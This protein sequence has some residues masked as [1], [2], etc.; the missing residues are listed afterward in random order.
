MGFRKNLI[1]L[2]LA[3]SLVLAGTACSKKL[4]SDETGTS[5]SGAESVDDGPYSFSVLDKKINDYN[6]E[7][8]K[9]MKDHLGETTSKET[10]GATPGGVP[11]ICKYTLTNDNKFE[12]LQMEKTLSNGMQVDEYFNMGDAMF[13]ARTTI[14]NDGTF[15]P[16]YKYYIAEGTLYQVDTEAQTVTKIADLSD[17]A[18]EEAKATLDIY[19]T[20]DEIRA[21]YA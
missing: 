17:P 18:I 9:F 11:A 5:S 8:N 2:G 12:V 6:L 3:L 21:L 7:L 1:A 15:D 4:S 16:V 20:F 19:L 10:Q 13:I 14:Y